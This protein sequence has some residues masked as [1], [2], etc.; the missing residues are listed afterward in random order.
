MQSASSA[1]IVMTSMRQEDRDEVV[2]GQVIDEAEV[3]DKEEECDTDARGLI[4][5]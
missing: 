3:E 4:K 2:E 1:W 5:A